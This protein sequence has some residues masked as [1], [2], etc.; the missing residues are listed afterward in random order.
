MKLV[1]IESKDFALWRQMRREIYPILDCEYDRREME[2]IHASDIWFCCFIEHAGAPIGLVELSSRN[3]VDGCLSSPVAYLEGLY[4]KPEHRGRGLGRQAMRLVFDWCRQ[5]GFSELATDAELEN[6]RA[7]NFY[8]MLGF[9]ETDRVV[10][11][12]IRIDGKK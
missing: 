10:E 2:Q 7:Q 5:R 4:L 11:Y 3:I 8:S 12:R 6:L 9:E 1:P